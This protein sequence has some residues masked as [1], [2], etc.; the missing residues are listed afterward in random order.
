MTSKFPNLLTL[1]S[2]LRSSIQNRRQPPRRPPSH[3]RQSQRNML[4]RLLLPSSG[5]QPLPQSSLRIPST[6]RSRN[7]ISQDLHDL[8]SPQTKRRPNPRRPFRSSQKQNYNSH[9]RRKRRLNP[10]DDQKA[11]GEKHAGS[12]VSRN[13]SSCS[14]GN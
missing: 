3:P 4:L 12:Q 7:L 11:R 8:R 6:P 2:S 1:M 9:P 14:S 10:L 5:R 13:F